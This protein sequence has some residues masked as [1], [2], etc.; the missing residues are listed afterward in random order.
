VAKRPPSSGTNGRRSGGITGTTVRIIHS[1]LLPEAMKASISLS[2]L[3]NFF[4]LMSLSVSVRATR[5]SACILSRSSAL[6]ISRIAS[7]P[8]VAVKLSG[9]N[10]SCALRY[11]SSDSNWRS[12][13]GVRPGSSTT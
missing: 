1:G 11:S 2:R 3:A 8:M 9:P 10:S 12:L 13:S 5:K 6:S 7:A 4:F